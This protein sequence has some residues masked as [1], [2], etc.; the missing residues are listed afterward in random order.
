MSDKAGRDPSH[1]DRVHALLIKWEHDDL[2]VAP[3]VNAI[4]TVFHR[5]YGF[6]VRQLTIPIDNS[7]RQ[8]NRVILDWVDD[9]DGDKVLLIVYYAGHGQ[10]SDPGR[11][12]IWSK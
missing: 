8:L 10:I 5:N 6:D 2:G 3:E 7:V 1:Y 12:L 11:S 4:D 9:Y